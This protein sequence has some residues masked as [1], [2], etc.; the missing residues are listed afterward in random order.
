MSLQR[1]CATEGR[2]RLISSIEFDRITSINFS[3]KKKKE[4]KNERTNERGEHRRVIEFRRRRRRRRSPSESLDTLPARC[5]R[6][7]FFFLLQ[8]I[9]A[10]M[11]LCY[12][13]MSTLKDYIDMFRCISDCPIVNKQLWNE[14]FPRGKTT[15]VCVCERFSPCSPDRVLAMMEKMATLPSPGS[16]Q[17]ERGLFTLSG[18][19]KCGRENVS[20]R[21]PSRRELQS[22]IV[23]VRHSFCA[24]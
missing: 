4:R 20:C 8:A 6:L 18:K 9:C 23:R 19:T 16:T 13:K 5:S 10:C 12:L 1:T 14:L 11:D 17:N 15:C 24:P 21:L 3:N 22:E 7:I 2:K